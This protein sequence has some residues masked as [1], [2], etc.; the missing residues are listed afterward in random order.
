MDIH[1]TI[2]MYSLSNWPMWCIR[3]VDGSTD[4]NSEGGGKEDANDEANH[5]L[6]PAQAREAI[7]RL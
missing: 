7:K 5:L 1:C 2:Y 4:Q 6:L 3:T